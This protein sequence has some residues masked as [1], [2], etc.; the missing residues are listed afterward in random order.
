[1]IFQK[2]NVR[3]KSFQ[4]RGIVYLLTV[5]ALLFCINNTIT[6]NAMGVKVKAYVKVTENLNIRESPKIS[7]K[8]VGKLLPGEIVTVISN[9]N[10]E[11]TEIQTSNGLTGFVS[12][13][14]LVI[15]EIDTEEYELISVA[16]ITKTDGSSENRNFNM[17]KA[18]EAINGSILQP[19]EIFAWYDVK[20]DG[21]KTIEEG[22]VGNASVANGY[23]KATILIN[24]KPIMGEGGGVCQVSTA[25]YNCIYKIGIEPTEIYHHSKTSSYVEKG[26]DATVN[27]SEN[28][29]Y[30]KNFV[31]TNTEDYP[32]MF[33]TYTDGPQV[34]MVA[35]KV[36]N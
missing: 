24:R 15:P 29:D 36:L 30:L 6:A 27:F 5:L 22:V 21:G 20:D 18:A 35:Y 19:K 2:R 34:V 16:V 26:M 9:N 23:K 31:F 32:I 14:F 1:M 12:N 7:S 17:A 4:R 10:D 13:E 11:W 3:K 8:I 33:E 28:K 25:L